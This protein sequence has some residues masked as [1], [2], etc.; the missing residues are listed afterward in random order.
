M[1][2]VS[3]ATGRGILPGDYTIPSFENPLYLL[4][5]NLHYNTLQCDQID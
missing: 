1:Q 4:V 5:P 3:N 2:V